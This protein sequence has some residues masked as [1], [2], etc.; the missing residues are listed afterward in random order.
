MP[1]DH[2]PKAPTAPRPGLRIAIGAV[3]SLLL[4]AAIFSVAEPADLLEAV[5]RARRPWL[6]AVIGLHLF[7]LLLRV[8]R[9]RRLLE[10]SGCWPP[11]GGIQSDTASRWLI[12]DT[13]FFGW[14]GNL[15]L[16]A[17][18]GEILAP[19]LFARRT[20]LPFPRIFGTVVVERGI[21]LVVLGGAFVVASLVL[22]IPSNVPPVVAQVVGGFTAAGLLL[23]GVL[24]ALA[25]G[26]GESSFGFLGEFVSGAGAL[27]DAGQFVTASALTVLIWA[28]EILCAW[29]ALLAF[30]VTPN[31]SAATLQVLSTTFS[32][33]L[34][35]VPAG[36]GVEQGVS[37]VVLDA[38]G[39]DTVTAVALSFVLSFAALVWI[40]PFG[41]VAMWRQ[42]AR[43]GQPTP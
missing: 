4:L 33:A 5:G 30:S 15:L 7:G 8:S 32:V 21:D 19:G 3:F 11:P 37:A 1:E 13:V 34:V 24:T 17:K 41:L 6:A 29:L 42:G 12:F 14:L 2:P 25:L 22:P 27:R 9:W 36:L 35:T 38:Y 18:L 40:V 28:T 23:L 31:L 43:L 20:G 39:I 10:G 26:K 16:P